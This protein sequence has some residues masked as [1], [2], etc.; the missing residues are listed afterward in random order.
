M[1]AKTVKVALTVSGSSFNTL[2]GNTADLNREGNQIDDTIFGQIFE[3]TQP[4]LIT[5]GVSA[6]AL[7]KGFAGY[8]ATLKKAGTSTSFTAEAMDNVSGNLYK[9]NDVTKNLWDREVALVFFDGS[10]GTPVIPAGN[11][12]TINHLIGQVEFLGA[13]TEPITVDGNFLPLLAFGKANSFNLA[14]T[15]ATI[16]T[17]AFEDA[18]GNSGFNIFEQ[19]LL[20]VDL[21]LSGFYRVSNNFNQ[22]LIN[23]EEIVIEINPDG[24]NQSFC[25]G[26]F[27]MATDNQTGDV[28]GSETESVTFVLSVPEGLGLGTVEAAPF[29]WVHES[30]STL[31]QAI[32]DLLTAWQAQDEVQIQYLPDGVAGFSGNGNV[33]DI[34]LAG[35]VEIMNEFT[36][37]IQGT[38]KVSVFP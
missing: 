7:Y 25:R 37:A 12:K 17:T 6:N 11:I 13:E 5:W 32:Q 4:G 23:R 18:Q 26:Y 9:M 38:G 14:Q 33:T 24:D 35:G 3:S 21:E 16:D 19:T 31:S 10:S 30:T 8:V 2:P 28:A 36:V 27:K 29:I 1:A 22:I 15:A 20:N 34:S